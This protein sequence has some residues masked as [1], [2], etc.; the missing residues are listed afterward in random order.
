[1]KFLKSQKKYIIYYVIVNIIAVAILFF[2]FNNFPTKEIITVKKDN[3]YLSSLHTKMEIQDDG[4]TIITEK[5]NIQGVKDGVFSYSH[6]FAAPDE[7]V[8]TTSIQLIDS[9]AKLTHE[10]KTSNDKNVLT[11]K[12]ETAFKGDEAVTVQYKVKGLVKHLHDGQMFQF[13]P[14]DSDKVDVVDAHFSITLPQGLSETVKLH[15]DG[16]LDQMSTKHENEKS[17]ETEIKADKHNV[18]TYQLRLWDKKQII[19]NKRG[20][21]VGTLKTS[22]EIEKDIEN[23]NHLL[24]QEAHKQQIFRDFIRIMYIIISSIITI[25]FAL[26]LVTN[27]W[28]NY[29]MRKYMRFEYAPESLGPAGAMKLMNPE[30]SY[31]SRGIKASILYMSLSG[32][33][34]CQKDRMSL[35][36]IKTKNAPNDELEEIKLLEK[37]LFNDGNARIFQREEKIVNS[38]DKTATLFLKYRNTIDEAAQNYYFSKD[39]DNKRP[40]NWLFNMKTEVFLIVAVIIQLI[41]L[42]I[43]NTSR[44]AN[45][46]KE[47]TIFEV[48]IVLV[49]IFVCAMMPLLYY[50]SQKRLLNKLHVD[51]LS[52]WES[53]KLFLAT[54]ALVR[55][56]LQDSS[57]QWKIFLMYA[58]A[59]G[60]EKTVLAAMK[61]ACPDKYEAFMSGS[62]RTILEVPDDYF[63]FQVK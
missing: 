39:E 60:S 24:K 47:Y 56:Q 44:V 27:F 30:S 42:F 33:I 52:E 41:L 22:N 45:S 43:I 16:T 40:N 35:Q 63:S 1:M 14:W 48:T 11:L 10:Y 31:L 61:V 34:R 19:A 29:S 15:A 49:S 38:S 9:S 20:L 59:F 7:S 58:T 36:M 62:D 23:R 13:N 32:L 5:M 55:K 17:I 3:P 18:D 57:E 21:P 54:P 50:V 6:Q 4:N 26:L 28:E 2:V 8:D 53:F 51:E 37:F 46:F 12:V 25:I